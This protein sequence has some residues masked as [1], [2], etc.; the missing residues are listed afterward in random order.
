MS[1]RKSRRGENESPEAVAVDQSDPLWHG[2]QVGGLSPGSSGELVTPDGT[3]WW[4]RRRN[5]DRRIV[6]RL[7]AKPGVP[8]VVGAVGGFHRS[9][10]APEDRARVWAELH[11]SF[12]GPGVKKVPVEGSSYKATWFVND[13]G[14]ELI[15]L[16][17][18]C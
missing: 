8:L 10:I 2:S 5:A 16:E 12:D 17:E 1:K 3:K 11:P 6:K 18:N 9:V 13:A 15:Y 14:G 4:A 7:I